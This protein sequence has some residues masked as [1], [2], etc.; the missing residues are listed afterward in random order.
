[1]KRLIF[2]PLAF[3]MLFALAVCASA[4]PEKVVELS[5]FSGGIGKAT[6]TGTALQAMIAEVEEKSGGSIKIKDFYDT[7][8][9]DSKTLIQSLVQGSIDMG[10]TGCSYYAG[11]VPEVQVFELPFLFE[12][13]TQARAAVNGP[14]RDILFEKFAAKGILVCLSGKTACATLPI[15]CAQ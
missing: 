1:M 5:V 4:S 15:M 13:V 3:V 11:V 10:I 2:L 12:N 9:G 8:L 6:P 14:A 7:E